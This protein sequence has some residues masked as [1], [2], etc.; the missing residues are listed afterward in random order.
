M[1]RISGAAMVPP[2]VAC[3]HVRL[4]PVSSDLFRRGVVERHALVD[5]VHR[6]KLDGS[7]NLVDR[8]HF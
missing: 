6:E 5:D 7:K 2:D 3:W 8:Q 1:S 4:A